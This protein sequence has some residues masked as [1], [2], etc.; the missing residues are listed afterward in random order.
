MLFA[1]LLIGCL[2][3]L[4]VSPCPEGH[5]EISF[6]IS[7]DGE[8]IV[9]TA[10]GRG[11]R[12]LYFLNLKTYEV[13]ILAQTDALEADPRFL[14][15]GQNIVYS[16]RLESQNPKGSWYL[17]LR[18]V[19][20]KK[21]KQLTYDPGVWVEDREPIPVPNSDKIV[22][23]R[24]HRL[25]RGSL[26]GFVR[27]DPA[28]YVINL[29]GTWL[30]RLSS[31]FVLDF[32][33]DGKKALVIGEFV[34]NPK[35]QGGIS[36]FFGIIPTPWDFEKHS[37]KPRLIKIGPYSTPRWSPDGRKIAFVSD[38]SKAFA[39]EVWLIDVEGKKMEQLTH[40]NTYIECLRFSPKGNFLLFLAK[41]KGP[42]IMFELYEI[43]VK[44]KK[45]KQI[46]DYRLF[47]D[48]LHWKPKKT[49]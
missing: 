26:G 22:F 27:T 20:G 47:D 2:R 36:S 8:K 23:T 25:V 46:A 43:D 29:D 31:P 45:I 44:W 35:W 33:P 21:I 17:F 19:D 41:V 32:S 34:V 5:R 14:P 15:D 7:P 10:T 42:D 3:Y 28:Q 39:Y 40:M 1:W 48:P 9:F 4:P 49:K 30:R 18:S 16:A 11:C 6:D 13:R 37:L 24:W 38:R 12:D